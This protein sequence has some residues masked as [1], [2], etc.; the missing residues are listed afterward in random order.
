MIKIFGLNIP[1]IS[2]YGAHDLRVEKILV[3]VDVLGR[4]KLRYD[5][6]IGTSRDWKFSACFSKRDSLVQK[7]YF[8]VL[9]GIEC[10][11]NFG[12]RF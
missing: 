1:N 3:T 7:N 6:I 2:S 9:L 11:W 4:G 10:V 12:G 5:F 8:G